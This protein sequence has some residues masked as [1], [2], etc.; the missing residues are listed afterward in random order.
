VECPLRN[1]PE[2]C[3]GDTMLHRGANGVWGERTGRNPLN[4]QMRGNKFNGVGWG[5]V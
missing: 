3:R 5:V 1:N 2:P 4:E